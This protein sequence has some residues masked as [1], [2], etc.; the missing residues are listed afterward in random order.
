MSANFT[1]MSLRPWVLGCGSEAHCILEPSTA[2]PLFARL[3]VYSTV[4]QVEKMSVTSLSAEPIFIVL[5]LVK[6]Y[7]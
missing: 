1:S 4:S 5:S 7:Y 3:C 6:S 2:T